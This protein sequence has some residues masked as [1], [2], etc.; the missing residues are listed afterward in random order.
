MSGSNIKYKG[1]EGNKR[2]KQTM[3]IT[4]FH[5]LIVTY[6]TTIDQT[7]ILLYNTSK[8]QVV[9]LNIKVEKETEEINKL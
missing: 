5:L 8:C 9:T 7:Y 6:Y 2:D 1:R 3:T 4:I